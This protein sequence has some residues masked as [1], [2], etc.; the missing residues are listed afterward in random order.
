[1]NVV[2]FNENLRSIPVS[3]SMHTNLEYPIIL[4]DKT[5]WLDIAIVEKKLNIEYDGLYWHKLNKM[6]G[7]MKDEERDDMLKKIGWTVIRVNENNINE[8]LEK[9]EKG[10]LM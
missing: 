10:D 7:K 2:I 3:S 8:L 1:V 5:K 4:G 6:T 9:L